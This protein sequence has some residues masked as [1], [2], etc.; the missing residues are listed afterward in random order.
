MTRQF[1]IKRAHRLR[2]LATAGG[3]ALVFLSAS[4]MS[5]EYLTGIEWPKPP[6]IT[7]GKTSADPP[8]DAIVLFGGKDLS[9]WKNGDRWKVEDG[10]AI[11]GD[12]GLERGQIRRRDV[13]AA[14]VAADPQAGF[15]DVPRDAACRLALQLA[16]PG[17]DR[18]E[19][20]ARD[21]FDGFLDRGLVAERGRVDG[22]Q[23]QPPGQRSHAPI[24]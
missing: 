1:E 10:A 2:L 3:A 18:A 20:G 5:K 16:P 22:A 24:P 14:A 9:A 13:G 12:V 15:A 21:G 23:I 4:C 7:P 19:A 8:S 17:R 6:I 11:V